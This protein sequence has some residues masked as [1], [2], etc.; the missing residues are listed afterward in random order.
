MGDLG[1]FLGSMTPVGF[2]GGAGGR[3]VGGEVK[4]KIEEPQRQMEAD[5]AKMEADRAA[6]EAEERA[7]R[8]EA[9]KKR[10][11]ERRGGG[12][13]SSTILSGAGGLTASQEQETSLSRRTLLGF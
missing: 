1:G 12:S 9:D 3:A 4:K 2:L 11:M 10:D 5:R 8:D 13:R 6:I 7:A